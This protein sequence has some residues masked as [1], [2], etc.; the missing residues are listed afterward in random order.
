MAW[1]FPVT[2]WCVLSQAKIPNR[3]LPSLFYQLYYGNQEESALY[4]W[5]VSGPLSEA[6]QVVSNSETMQWLDTF[7]FDG[8][9]N[10][11]FV[12]NKLQLFLFGGMDFEGSDANFRVSTCCCILFLDFFLDG[13]KIWQVPVG[14][15]SYLTGKPRPAS[16][17][18]SQSQPVSHRIMLV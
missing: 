5:D 10:L 15:N 2:Q 9:G 13:A 4:G 6:F 14:A 7:A 17:P 12:S 3:N 16:L 1:L 11:L 18:C 8:E